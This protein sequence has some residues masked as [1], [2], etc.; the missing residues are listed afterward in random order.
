VDIQRS[1]TSWM[2][3]PFF[4]P[5]THALISRRVSPQLIGSLLN[6]FFFGTLLIQVYVYR[7]C[8]PKDSFGF[9]L[10]SASICH[11]EVLPSHRTP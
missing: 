7:V 5:P 10:L 2:S 6:L 1:I 8:F 9:K 11:A 3:V 4:S